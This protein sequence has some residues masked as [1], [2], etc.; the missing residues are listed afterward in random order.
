MKHIY[1]SFAKA[2]FLMLLCLMTTLTAKAV[3]ITYSLTTHVDGRTMTQTINQTEGKDLHI[4]SDMQRG[5]TDYTYYSD[6]ELTNEITTVPSSDA[7]VYVDYVFNPTIVLSTD[8]FLV[9]YYIRG[10]G[11]T[12][13]YG[14]I[15][16][17]ATNDNSHK[18]YAKFAVMGDCYSIYLYETNTKKYIT[19]KNDDHTKRAT[20]SSRP[21]VGWQLMRNTNTE[22]G[23]STVKRFSLGT[24]ES[25]QNLPGY[26]ISYSSSNTNVNIALTTSNGT[27]SNSSSTDKEK[28]RFTSLYPFL[29]S[30]DATKP[31]TIVYR[32]MQDYAPYEQRAIIVRQLDAAINV[33]N[34]TK[35]IA[36]P[37]DLKKAIQQDLDE[38]RDETTFR[39]EYYKDAA[40]TN[41]YATDEKCEY[42]DVVVWVKEI[43]L[44]GH[45]TEVTADRWITICLPY[46]VADVNEYFGD[47]A[48]IVNK[49]TGLNVSGNKYNLEFTAVD[50]IKP[51]TPYMFKAKN[52]LK[53]K[54]LTLYKTATPP[55]DKD[56][57]E[58]EM[59]LSIEYA[60][61]NAIV[62]MRGTYD[63][64]T[65][66][67]STDD[68]YS[69]FM[70][71]TKSNDPTHPKY[72][73]DWADEAPK[74]YKVVNNTREIK[75]FRCW[76]DIKDLDPASGAKTLGFV[77]ETETGIREVVNPD[78][79][80]FA[81][82]NIYNTNGQLVR[83]NA[84]GT[85]GLPKGLYIMGGR[86]VVVK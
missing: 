80:S 68:C 30:G 41:Q 44:D 3:S 7:T 34:P 51:N 67:A 65:L 23:L 10:G 25:G 14:T 45:E 12:T 36:Y 84:T 58:D 6:P 26:Y 74:F 75:P 33:E 71:Y 37:S 5:Y 66:T 77:A 76:F 32:F 2:C 43:F 15:H 13:D 54:Y 49:F 4:P 48:V 21:S 70:G 42:K 38:T 86:K 28:A 59:H 16:P 56:Q 11:N 50:N 79:T 40:M 24:V 31:Y 20:Q 1:T 19:W 60:D 29:A 17:D 73:E 61:N 9:P 83:A 64:K 78:G 52:V 72:A 39:Y 22:N 85:E 8:E 81:I 57:S 35:G 47:G 18:N 62:T 55:L 53:G 69:F 27:V 63:G 82:G 46:G